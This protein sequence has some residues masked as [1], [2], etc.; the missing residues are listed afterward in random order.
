M[1]EEKKPESNWEVQVFDF[2]VGPVEKA[3]IN[4]GESPVQVFFFILAATGFILLGATALVGRCGGLSDTG[5]RSFLERTTVLELGSVVRIGGVDGVC[6]VVK[7]IDS[8]GSAEVALL[9]R[10]SLYSGDLKL[11]PKTLFYFLSTHP[12]E[13]LSYLFSGTDDLYLQPEEFTVIETS[14]F[15]NDIR[16]FY[17]TIFPKMLLILLIL[18]ILSL[19]LENISFKRR[20]ALMAFQNKRLQYKSVLSKDLGR[21]Q[22][23]WF[24]A[25]AKAEEENNVLAWG[26]AI[27]SCRALLGEVLVSLFDGNSP[28]EILKKETRDNIPDIR[29]VEAVYQDSIFIEQNINTQ[30]FQIE[31]KKKDIVIKQYEKTFTSFGILV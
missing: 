15:T 18:A 2:A 26:E 30:G 1:A 11:T 8:A 10:A 7:S 27:A 20:T 25:L 12:T 13:T 3:L 9:N 16:Y 19:Y 6:G 29:I 21:M 22:S 31:K 5:D 17:E 24:G 23:V 14:R 4:F 28:E